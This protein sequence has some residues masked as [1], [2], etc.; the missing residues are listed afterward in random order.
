M[1]QHKV[2]FRISYFVTKDTFMFR[3]CVITLIFFVM[4]RQFEQVS[5]HSTV[6]GNVQGPRFTVG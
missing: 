3:L 1:V 5:N 4:L 2:Y 6:T